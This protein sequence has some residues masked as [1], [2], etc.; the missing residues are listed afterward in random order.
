MSS[1]KQ[2]PIEKIATKIRKMLKDQDTKDIQ[3]IMNESTTIERQRMDRLA[4]TRKNV[5]EKKKKPKKI[6]PPASGYKY[7]ILKPKEILKQGIEDEDPYMIKDAMRKGVKIGFKT[8]P[9]KESFQIWISNYTP[10]YKFEKIE[11]R[12][13]LEN[14]KTEIEEEIAEIDMDDEDEQEKLSVLMD[15][16]LNVVD[17]L[18]NKK[19]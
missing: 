8:L 1:K 4:Q 18:E 15:Y 7:Q 3:K 19:M 5:L 13:H 2:D 17:I 10:K 11:W 9:D 12:D 6:S 14:L 16:V